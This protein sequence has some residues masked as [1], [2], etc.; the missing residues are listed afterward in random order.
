MKLVGKLVEARESLGLTLEEISEKTRI[1]KEFLRSIESGDLS[2]LPSVYVHVFLRKYA[3]AVGFRDWGLIENC[4]KEFGLPSPSA[5]AG[6]AGIGVRDEEL[7]DIADSE[8]HGEFT[9]G[10]VWK[11]P[12]EETPGPSWVEN[13]PDRRVLSLAVIVIGGIAMVFA[14]TALVRSVSGPHSFSGSPREPV[15]AVLPASPDSSGRKPVS[16]QAAEEIQESAGTGHPASSNA[17]SAEKEAPRA[18]DVESGDAGTRRGEYVRRSTFSTGF[19][20]KSRE[21]VGPLTSLTNGAR[22][23]YYF[24]EVLDQKG[25]RLYHLWEYRGRSVKRI[26]V[27]RAGASSWRVWSV[28]TL[29]PDMPGT[30]TVK[31]VNGDGTV[32]HADS[33]EYAGR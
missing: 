5:L 10:E 22:K 28:K 32:L 18:D 7:L 21:P 29:P 11:D 26:P 24:S 15:A 33:L 20:E 30:W 23:V 2:L 27:G 4:R 14:L 3:K 17:V 12:A 19:D 1:R 31:V 16:V 25:K 8:L 9:S 13:L 6:N